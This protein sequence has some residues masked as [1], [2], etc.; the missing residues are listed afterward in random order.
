MNNQ[1]IIKN[2]I[3]LNM[4]IKK[5]CYECKIEKPINEFYHNK[6]LKDG[7]S[8][9]CK[10]CQRKREEKYD[11]FK[12]KTEIVY[13]KPG[14]YKNE[15]Q[16]KSTFEVMEILGWKYNQKNGIWYKWPVKNSKGEW[17]LPGIC[18]NKIDL[19]K[20]KSNTKK[21]IYGSSE[22][23]KNR[24]LTIKEP[25]KNY[26][27]TKKTSVTL[28]DE[29]MNEIRKLYQQKGITQMYLASKFNV[30]QSYIHNILFYKR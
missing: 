25:P 9:L 19:N 29:Q 21:Y 23:I 4:N 16:R 11:E 22:I 3:N 17:T 20:Q 10:E 6:S 2:P 7:Y 26:K 24:K 30:S 13:S 5:I 28:S 14:K 8:N 15:N 27:P 1:N 18:S 12:E